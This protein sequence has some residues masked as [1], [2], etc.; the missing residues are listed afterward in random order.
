MLACGDAPGFLIDGFPRNQDN[1]D[2][3]TR[4]MDDKVKVHFVLHLE[5]PIEK[6]LARCMGRSQ[7][8]LGEFLIY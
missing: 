4:E 1:L 6:C 5:A 3:W 2:G 7:S 8:R